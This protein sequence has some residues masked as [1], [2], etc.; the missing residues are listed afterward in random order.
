M[1]RIQN[2]LSGERLDGKSPPPYLKF[3]SSTAFILMT[4]CLAVFTDIFLYGIVVPVLPFSIT[5]RA[6]VAEQ[7][8]QRW[9]SV[10]LAVYGA[11]LLVASPLTGWLAD[12]SSSR[13]L[14]LLAGLVCLAGSTIMLCLARS[15]A[16]LVLGRLLQGLSAAVV[17][18][19]GTALLVDTVGQAEIGQTLGYVSLSVS[20][21]YLL[22][23]LM[24]GLVY[25]RVG[26]VRNI[27]FELSYFSVG[28]ILITL[29]Y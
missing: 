27:I 19:V 16:L 10:L 8:A 25:E 5:E 29:H 15:I 1:N 18:T 20:I 3:R 22:A 14:P 4:I 24:G 6:G 28:K 23:P 9:I 26:Y 12:K 13:R 21:G 11:A 7:D 17:W 2:F